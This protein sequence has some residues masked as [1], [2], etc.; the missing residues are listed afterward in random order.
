VNVTHSFGQAYVND[1][2]NVAVEREEIFVGRTSNGRVDA[3]S[4]IIIVVPFSLSATC[5]TYIVAFP[6]CFLGQKCNRLHGDQYN[7]N[8]RFVLYF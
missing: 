7:A 3:G 1:A 4:P 8:T 5:P 2:T 6:D